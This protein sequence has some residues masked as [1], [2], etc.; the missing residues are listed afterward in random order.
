MNI[1]IKQVS[2][3]SVTTGAES[4]L[5]YSKF[6]IHLFET[7]PTHI[8]LAHCFGLIYFDVPARWIW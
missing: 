2:L 7:K 1:K 8:T 5:I 4:Y 3:K 6:S